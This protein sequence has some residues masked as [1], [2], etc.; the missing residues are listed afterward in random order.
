MTADQIF[1]DTHPRIAITDNQQS[2]ITE[3]MKPFGGRK[4]I[5]IVNG[6][7]QEISDFGKRIKAALGDAKLLPDI[8]GG[9]ASHEDGSSM[10][11]VEVQ[12]GDNDADAGEALL[13]ALADNHVLPVKQIG[14]HYYKGKPGSLVITISPP[15]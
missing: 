12:Y 4:A 15:N 3:A 14:F 11:P 9:F 6:T 5:I 10:L 8:G 2:A 13:R 7:T 1:I